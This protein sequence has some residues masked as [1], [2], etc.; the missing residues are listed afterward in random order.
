MFLVANSNRSTHFSESPS[1]S[2]E[3]AAM[4][5]CTI[6]ESSNFSVAPAEINDPNILSV[7]VDETNVR[8]QFTLSAY[9]KFP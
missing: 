9:P 5:A 3:H 7:V 4:L 2:Q 8:H 1:I 6:T